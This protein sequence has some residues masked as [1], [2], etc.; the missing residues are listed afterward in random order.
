[1]TQQLFLLITVTGSQP[2]GGS[3]SFSVTETLP[4]GIT[5]SGTPAAAPSAGAS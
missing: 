5:L 2:F 3:P 1:M 4:A